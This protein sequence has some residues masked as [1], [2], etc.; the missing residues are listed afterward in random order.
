MTLMTRYWKLAVV[1]A[2]SLMVVGMASS[3]AQVS[4]PS[5]TE[6][7][8]RESLLLEGPIIVSGNDVGFRIERTKEGIPVGKVVVRIDGKWV[9]T[10]PSEPVQ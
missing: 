10:V 2:L 4:Q 5:P 3:R 9:D 8:R 6:K 7:M 1:W